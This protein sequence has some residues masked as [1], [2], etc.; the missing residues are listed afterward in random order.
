MQNISS[1]SIGE[2]WSLH[3][4]EKEAK[5]KC[6]DIHNF[7]CVDQDRRLSLFDVFEIVVVVR[8]GGYLYL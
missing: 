1:Y 4:K 7:Y 6:Y 3:K 5:N 8:K 2:A